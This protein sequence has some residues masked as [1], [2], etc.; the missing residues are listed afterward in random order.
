MNI[1]LQ[2]IEDKIIQHGYYIS[3]SQDSL[4]NNLFSRNDFLKYQSKKQNKNYIIFTLINK[5]SDEISIQLVTCYDLKEK[6]QIFFSPITGAFSDIY[7]PLKKID[8][9]VLT[10]FL[11][12]IEVYIQIHFSAKKIIYKLPPEL[13]NCEDNNCLLNAFHNRS[14]EI[15]N[16]DLNFHLELIS[17]DEFRRGLSSG[18]R[19]RL[20]KISRGDVEFNKVN[21]EANRFLVYETIRLN[22]KAQGYPMTMSWDNLNDLYLSLSEAVSFF[23]LKYNESI[24]ASAICLELSPENIYVFYWGEN[25]EFRKLSPIVKLAEQLYSFYLQAGCRTLDIGISTENSKPNQGLIDFKKNIGCSL[26]KK[27]TVE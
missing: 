12:Y 20:N 15:H 26:T 9:Q 7:M 24:V 4:I 13:Y 6:G 10:D 25:P 2:N 5:Q 18:T 3:L 22:R 19:Q 14:W 27:I 8:V 11:Q 16:I 21:D 1:V 17:L 23:T